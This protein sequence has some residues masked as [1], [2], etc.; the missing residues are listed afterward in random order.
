M[1]V[2]HADPSFGVRSPNRLVELMDARLVGLGFGG[3]YLQN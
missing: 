3:G 1:S 2:F